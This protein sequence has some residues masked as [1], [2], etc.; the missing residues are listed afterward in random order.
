MDFPDFPGCISGGT[1]LDEARRMAQEALELHVGGMIEDG[2]ALP[3]GSSLETIMADPENA[4]AVAFV[5]TVPEAADRTVRVN[6]TLP[7]RLLRRIDERAKN[8]S[9]FLARAAEKALSES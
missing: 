8:R 9:A 6:I 4:D 7:E 5:V 2:E 3:V 1:T